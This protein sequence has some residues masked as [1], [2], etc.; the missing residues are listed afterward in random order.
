MLQLALASFDSGPVQQ[1]VRVEGVVGAAAFALAESE[2][3]R[4]AAL[5]YR[6]AVVLDLRG[7][8]AVLARQVLDDILARCRHLRVQFEGLE[9]QLGLDFAV[10]A[11]QCL[12]ERVQPDRAP[13]AGHIGYEIDL[14]GGSV[15]MH[16]ESTRGSTGVRT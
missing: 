1:P 7:C 13:G 5:A 15:G 11:G 3:H 6:F 8:D 2:A 10:E 14:H 16:C 9:V 4:L 12:L